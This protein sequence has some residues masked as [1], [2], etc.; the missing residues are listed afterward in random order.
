MIECKI[1]DSYSTL[2]WLIAQQ[3]RIRWVQERPGRI[4][5]HQAILES[6]GGRPCHT[7]GSPQQTQPGAD[8]SKRTLQHNECIQSQVTIGMCAWKM[9]HMPAGIT[10]PLSD[11]LARL[12]RSNNTTCGQQQYCHVQVAC[13]V[14]AQKLAAGIH[15]RKHCST[16]KRC[17]HW[18]SYTPGMRH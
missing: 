5:S 17:P 13:A 11:V 7:V 8:L 16:K 4:G 10:E 15:V 9:L 3:I 12:M 18:L 6:A 2:S 14:T 1:I